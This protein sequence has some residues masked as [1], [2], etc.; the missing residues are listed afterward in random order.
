M[1]YRFGVKVQNSKS[2]FDMKN[3]AKCGIEITKIATQLNNIHNNTLERI[4]CNDV[5]LHNCD[6]ATQSDEFQ[7][8][9]I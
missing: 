9:V 8:C 2:I 3:E 4:V 7:L 6:A 5:M 1:F